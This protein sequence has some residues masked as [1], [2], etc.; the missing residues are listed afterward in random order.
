[1]LLATS[2]RRVDAL[3]ATTLVVMWSSGFIGAELGTRYASADTLLAWRYVIAAAVLAAWAWGRGIRPRVHVVVRHGTL[4]ALCQ[5]LYLGGVV[6]AIGLGVPAGTAALIAATQPMLV[7]ALAAP[8]LAERTT[9]RQRWGLGTGVIGVGLVVAGDL[10]VGDA[11][12]WAFLLPVGGTLA[13]SAGTLLERRW[14]LPESLLESLTIQTVVAA[15][16]FVAAAGA[17]GHLRPPG[18][19][20]FWWAVVWMVVL[21]GIGGYGSYLFV[22]RRGGATRVSALLYLTPPTTMAWAYAMFGQ[23]PGVLAVPGVAIC[24]VAVYLVLA[25]LRVR[26]A[27]SG[28]VAVGRE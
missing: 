10:G 28:Q 6:S 19:A 18:D 26:T 11:P 12:A 13:L 2:G 4:G 16:F 27:R 15:A 17:T 9:V 25:R 3:A 8:L 23:P 1:M 22:L 5:A 21:S 20:G 7:A 24:A 14:Q